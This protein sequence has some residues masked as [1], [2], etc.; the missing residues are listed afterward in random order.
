MT[1]LLC[2]LTGAVRRGAREPRVGGEAN[3]VVDDNVDRP[4]RRVRRQV[5]QVERLVDDALAGERSVSVHQ[6]RH[7]LCAE[8][9]EKKKQ[10]RCDH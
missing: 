9:K 4:A 6:N 2:V 3:L 10:S 5:R 8:L 7:D 1:R